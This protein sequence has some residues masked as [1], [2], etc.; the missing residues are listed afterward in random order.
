MKVNNKLWLDCT[1]TY[2]VINIK[3]FEQSNKTIVMKFI[4]N[5]SKDRK[6]NSNYNNI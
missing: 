6:K 3:A 5:S 2:V 4:L 1:T